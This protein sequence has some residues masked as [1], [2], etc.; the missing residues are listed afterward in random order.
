M[1]KHIQSAHQDVLAAKK[2]I[3]E[4]KEQRVA[5]GVSQIC[6]QQD[7]NELN[8]SNPCRVDL[9]PSSGPIPVGSCLARPSS[10]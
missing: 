9:P 1:H 7:Q 5:S 8:E 10:G 4:Q 6:E 3:G 2:K